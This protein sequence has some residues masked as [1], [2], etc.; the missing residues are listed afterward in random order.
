MDQWASLMA[1]G[2]DIGI[3]IAAISA[4]A[5]AA[6]AFI[7]KRSSDRSLHAVMRASLTSLES[8]AGPEIQLQLHNDG[9]GTA[10]AVACAIRTVSVD[11]QDREHYHDAFPRGS[12]RPLV[13]RIDPRHEYPADQLYGTKLNWPEDDIFWVVIR[14][15]DA[16]GLRWELVEHGITQ[17]DQPIQRLRAPGWKDHWRFWRDAADW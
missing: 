16:T 3:A 7:S 14:W 9:L 8:A 10:Y 1:A 4:S 5:S 11:D 17:L 15:T 6:S 13:R 2:A 12:K